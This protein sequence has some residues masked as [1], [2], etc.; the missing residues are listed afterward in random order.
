MRFKRTKMAILLCGLVIGTSACATSETYGTALASA[1]DTVQI[2]VS[3]LIADYGF[4][5]D[6]R[7]TK[8]VSS[9]F[10]E[11]G[12]LVVPKVGADVTGRASIAAAFG[13]TWQQVAKSGQQRRHIIS[14]VR[15]SNITEKSADFRAIMNVTGKPSNGSPQV[16]LTGFYRGTAVWTDEGWRLKRLEIN[17]D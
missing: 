14:S 2:G 3:N 6:R 8:T 13:Q 1:S 17:I 12:Q 9:L 4:H 5:A 10:T 15:L 16:Y 7:D 11:D